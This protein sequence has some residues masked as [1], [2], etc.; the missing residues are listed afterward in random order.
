MRVPLCACYKTNHGSACWVKCRGDL[1]RAEVK[2]NGSFKFGVVG[3][4]MDVNRRVEAVQK[5]TPE[6]RDI[7]PKTIPSLTS[8]Q[9][10]RRQ[11]R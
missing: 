2:R 10:G 8:V 7:W 6:K 1:H 4:G 3:D 11:Q 5:K 9:L